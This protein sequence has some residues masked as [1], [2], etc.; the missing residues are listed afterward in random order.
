MKFKDIALVFLGTVVLILNLTSAEM[1]QPS[2]RILTDSSDLTSAQSTEGVI[3]AWQ[4]DVASFYAKDPRSAEDYQSPL[5][6]KEPIDSIAT[7]DNAMTMPIVDSGSIPAR[8][9]SFRKSEHSATGHSQFNSRSR[10]TRDDWLELANRTAASV[11]LERNDKTAE[12]SLSESALTCPPTPSQWSLALV[13]GLFISI[14]FGGWQTHFP[15]LPVPA[16][17]HWRLDDTKRFD[18]IGEAVSSTMSQIDVE[19]SLLWVRHRQPVSVL[20]RHL[21]LATLI[22][23]CLLSFFVK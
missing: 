15:Q 10:I 8:T 19:M 12:Q 5:P 20:G 13:G 11:H 1:H 9:V 18:K 4:H 16:T 21:F 2:E 7:N 22:I 23:A 14:L 17:V 3:Q 6:S